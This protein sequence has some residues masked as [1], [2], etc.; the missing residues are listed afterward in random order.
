MA[1]WSTKEERLLN[2]MAETW[3]NWPM[4]AMENKGIYA[5]V[6]ANY[7]DLTVLPNI[8]IMVCKRNHPKMAA[9]FR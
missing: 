7:N 5:M 1:Q 9:A 4:V 3:L 6:W 2:K 8:G